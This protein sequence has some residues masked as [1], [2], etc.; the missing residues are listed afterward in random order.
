MAFPYRV[1]VIADPHVH[2]TTWMP[3][4][5]SDGRAAVRSWAETAASTRVFNE[6]VPAFRAALDRAVAEGVRLVI[7]PGDLTD[8]GQ[9]ANIA[10]AVALIADYERRHGLRVFMT[11]G[12]HDFWARAGRP[13]R[14]QFV[15]SA[16]QTVTLDSRAMP[17]GDAVSAPDTAML[18]A[19][20]ALALMADLGFCP[21]LGDRHFETPFGRD[22]AWGARTHRAASPSGDVAFD[23]IDA[24][25]LIEPIDGLWLLSIDANVIGPRDG[26][27]DLDDPKQ[28][29]DPSD[30]GWPG[31]LRARPYLLA[32]MRE[33][34]ARARAGGKALIAFSHYPALDALAG[35]AAEE[36]A[37]F[38][39]SPL[40]R[41][42][43]GGDVARAFAATGVRLHLSGHLHVNDTA[44]FRDAGAG[45]VNLAVPSP[46]AYPPAMKVLDAAPDRVRVRTVR[47]DSVPN[48]ALA[49]AAYRAE[50]LA[51]GRPMPMAASAADHVGFLGAHLRGLVADRYMAR[52]WPAEMAGFARDS[53]FADLERLLWPDAAPVAATAATALQTLAEDWYRLRKAA[54]L[55]L[56]LIPAGRL[57]T[58][59]VWT[60][61]LD[62]AATGDL[63]ARFVALLRLLGRYLD[64]LPTRD[65]VIDLDALAP[66][67][68]EDP[69]P[70]RRIV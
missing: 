36:C 30:G 16:G 18:G 20:E 41:R 12:N 59:R 53:R 47:L 27:S 8:D 24:S 28:M 39:T 57:A 66:V 2:D 6:S 56:D 4:G 25:Y 60:T 21:R 23:M 51:A 37:L 7:I 52:E 13:Q 22:P 15:D 46:A 17:E 63:A 58:Y 42:T 49:F 69:A 54:D 38:P 10:A 31:V 32:W 3:L 35:G 43:P 19:P 5:P 48:H 9:R 11:P 68:A 64:R 14:K 70:E 61:R 67:P 44:I 45:F 1:A 34:A 55:A 65:T 40:A 26:A 62:V 29:L 50:A 33:V